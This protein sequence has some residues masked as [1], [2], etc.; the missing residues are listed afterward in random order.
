MNLRQPTAAP[1]FE[2][3]HQVHWRKYIPDHVHA[4]LEAVMS[5][6]QFGI[7]SSAI[8]LNI[9]NITVF[10]RMGVKDVMTLSLLSLSVSDLFELCTGGAVVVLD[11]LLKSPLAPRYERHVDLSGFFYFISFVTCIG[12]STSTNITTLIALERCLCVVAPFKL[13]TLVTMKRTRIA[14]FC[15]V[16]FGVLSNFPNLFSIRFVRV[17]NPRLNTTRV[18]VL[19]TEERAMLENLTVMVNHAFVYPISLVIVVTSSIIMIKGLRR[20][21]KFRQKKMTLNRSESAGFVKVRDMSAS[22]K[23]I[24]QSGSPK[25]G[26]VPAL[27]D[28]PDVSKPTR[29]SKVDGSGR[30]LKTCSSNGSGSSCNN[31]DNDNC[32]NVHLSQ[33]SNGNRARVTNSNEREENERSDKSSIM[34]SK[35]EI[36]NKRGSKDVRNTTSNRGNNTVTHK[37]AESKLSKIGFAQEGGHDQ[38]M[39]V[40]PNT[41]TTAAHAQRPVLSSNN[42]R[43]I[44]ML[45]V[46][47]SVT[48]VFHV[49]SILIGVWLTFDQRIKP[50]GFYSNTFDVVFKSAQLFYAWS[51]SINTFVYIKYNRKYKKTLSAM[52]FRLFRCCK[53]LGYETDTSNP[54]DDN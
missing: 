7:F 46:V 16:L 41:N 28:H 2:D 47:A 42:I 50:G 27:T 18:E 44:K 3:D 15:I 34:S 54:S 17:Y 19:F 9:L 4:I 45:L 1:G 33:D 35:N 11:A 23:Q 26:V 8:L 21:A 52:W 5:K 38:S 51:M 48:A 29:E 37:G 31:V 24:C 36:H 49:I 20:S 22:S 12:Q 14:I 6:M 25:R 40:T 43:L 39:S 53:P 10:L 30:G 32:A 13:K